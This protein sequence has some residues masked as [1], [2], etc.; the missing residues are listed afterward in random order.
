M[1]CYRFGS[2]DRRRRMME[3]SEP[4][5]NTLSKTAAV[6][7][8]RSVDEVD[9]ACPSLS[10]PV[11]VDV[12]DGSSI[13][14]R[15]GHR[16]LR[17]LS[18]S[19]S[20]HS[21]NSSSN[22]NETNF[23]TLL[24]NQTYPDYPDFGVLD[25]EMAVYARLA[26]NVSMSSIQSKKKEKDWYETSL[27][28]PLPG[29]KFKTASEKAPP[30][31]IPTLSSLTSTPSLSNGTGTG[32]VRAQPVRVSDVAESEEE[33]NQS[34]GEQI[35]SQVDHDDVEEEEQ[36][37]FDF[38]SI[39]FESPKN[40]ELI[41]AGKWEPYREVSKPFETSDIY[42]Y[43]AKYR[44]QQSKGM[45]TPLQPLACQPLLNGRHSANEST[46]SAPEFRSKPATLV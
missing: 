44:Q 22:Y 17:H 31:S 23:G 30:P 24:P 39:A 29:R 28:S 1:T 2:L 16:T 36:V 33:D 37:V 6:E 15:F 5:K 46:D 3:S 40:L 43:S 42:K 35:S 10:L 13:G 7:G 26:H 34:E 9:A 4:V 11:S 41:T 14:P 20:N 25:S 45:Y 27:D 21:N 38:D 12:I 18:S 19:S 32:T 8:S